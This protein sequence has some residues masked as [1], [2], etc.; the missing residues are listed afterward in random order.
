MSV[1]L[2]GPTPGGVPF[3]R[4]FFNATIGEFVEQLGKQASP[5]VRLFLVDGT[6]L[7]ICNIE[8][9]AEDYMALRVYLPAQEAC[10]TTIHLVPYSLI[11]RIEI[12]AAQG[13]ES[14]RVG[15]QWSPAPRKKR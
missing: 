2:L 5:K 12:G 1:M 8:T 4:S 9:L 10:D 14:K 3:N 13:E 7:D 11:Y 6:V 15:F